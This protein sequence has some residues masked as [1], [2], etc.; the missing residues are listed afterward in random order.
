MRQSEE[1][2]LH[3]PG[4]TEKTIGFIRLPYALG[5]LIFAFLFSPAGVLPFVLLD[6]SDLNKAGGVILAATNLQSVE[7]PWPQ[8]VVYYGI[9]YLAVFFL[10]YVIRYL[11]LRILQAEPELVPVLIGGEETFHKAFG[12]I[13]SNWQPA[14][15]GLVILAG[16]PFDPIFLSIYPAL[17]PISRLDFIVVYVVSLFIIT[18]FGW[19]YLSSIWGLRELGKS[20][21]RLK[22]FVEDRTL[23]VRPLGSLSLSLAFGY[24]GGSALLILV[25]AIAPI[26]GFR[27][28]E[29]IAG[30]AGALILGLTLF[31][32]PLNSVHGKMLNEKRHEQKSHLEEYNSL[33][34][35]FKL[36]DS[37]PGLG[38]EGRLEALL[39]HEMTERRIAAIPTWPFDTGILGRFAAIFLSVTAILI[40]RI[41]QLTFHL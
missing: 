22:A 10:C 1:T 15:L 7:N 41:I 17:G 39:F 38:R 20:S 25:S 24:F 18:N 35:S 14:L 9:F 37:T 2:G 36:K 12:R 8:V 11:R 13:T 5:C 33:L 30:Y 27:T 21:L 4:Y 28:P 32:L 34:Q 29:N 40:S 19:I 26:P 3:R 31:F 23:G 16:V 6:T